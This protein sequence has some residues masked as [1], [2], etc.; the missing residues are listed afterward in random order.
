VTEHYGMEYAIRAETSLPLHEAEEALR[1]YLARNGF[2]VLHETDVKAIH[3]HYSLDYPEF[4]ILKV[5]RAA[6]FMQCPMASTAV[7]LDPGSA[8][9]RRESSSTRPRA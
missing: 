4:K 7:R 1:G 3:N 5:V 6:H 8:C 2:H 9:S